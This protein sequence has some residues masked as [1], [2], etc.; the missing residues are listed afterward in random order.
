MT[1]AELGIIL[2]DRQKKAG[3]LAQ[4]MVDNIGDDIIIDS[5]F[6]CSGCG[7]REIPEDTLNK[8]ISKSDTYDDLIESVEG[9]Q[10]ASQLLAL[11]KQKRRIQK[12]NP[13]ERRIKNET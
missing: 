8:L 9:V 12:V 10:R 2:R 6:T 13:K 11:G 7:E 4:D 3:Y 5:Y 1:R